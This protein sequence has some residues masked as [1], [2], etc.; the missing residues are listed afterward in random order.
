M[1]DDP[2]PDRPGLVK[3]LQ[4][5]QSNYDYERNDL[6]RSPKFPSQYEIC[7]QKIIMSLRWVIYF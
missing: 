3:I 2:E 6:V 7:I 4:S 5:S 1:I